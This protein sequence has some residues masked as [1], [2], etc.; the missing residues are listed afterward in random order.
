MTR[1]I[2]PKKATGFALTTS[3]AP[4]HCCNGLDPRRDG[5]MVPS[6]LGMTGALAR[7][8]S[9]IR[10]VTPTASNLQGT[11]VPDG[12]SILGP[13]NDFLRS[14]E[15]AEVVHFHGLWQA[16][17]RRGA[18]AARL[19]K[20][21][22]SGRGSRDGRTLGVTAQ[23]DQKKLYTALVE[24]KNL[25]R[26]SCLHALSRPEVGHLRAIAPRT[27]VALIPNG[28]DLRP[29]DNL[30]PRETLEEEFPELVGKF[31][32]LFYGRLHV[33]KGLDLLAQALGSVAKDYPQAHVVLAGNDDG[34]L[35]PFLTMADC[36]GV[37]DRV[38]V[39]G[40]VS[41]DRA[42]KVWAR[43]DGFV[44]P[45]YSEGFS[46]AIL[47]ALAARLAGRSIDDRLPLLRACPGRRWPSSSSQR[48]RG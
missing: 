25:R 26:A 15:A 35:D 39:I 33:K 41:G 38:T 14:I 6:I 11:V 31:V 7:R 42:R 5:G 34:A 45:S 43:A 28:V 10:I 3:T 13:E 32:L 4:L 18:R 17:T 19:A 22:V 36:L 1:L 16:Q 24:G 9:Q 12:V 47:E 23:S 29:F 44:L 21:A 20:R 48:W 2:E 30:P 8:G 37:R 46:M 27:P 40:H